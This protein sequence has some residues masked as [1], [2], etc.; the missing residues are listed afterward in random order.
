MYCHKITVEFPRYLLGVNERMDEDAVEEPIVL[1]VHVVDH[2]Q[3]RVENQG[4]IDYLLEGSVAHDG[5]HPLQ[6]PIEN[7][8]TDNDGGPL[9]VD[10]GEGVV[11][12]VVDLNSLWI[13][14]CC[15]HSHELFEPCKEWWVV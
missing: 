9:K 3:T 2:E 13:Y 4:P 15:K 14:L 11:S 7:Q 8:L 6:C 1:K 10:R 12:Q 5:Q